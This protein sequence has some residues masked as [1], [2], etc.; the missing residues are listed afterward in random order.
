MYDSVS[1][2]YHVLYHS[3]N[4][5][6]RELYHSVDRLYHVQIPHACRLAGSN[7]V[8]LD[9]QTCSM[10]NTTFLLIPNAFE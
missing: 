1:I 5:L 6:Y 3:V 8:A 10:N 9:Q 7:K 4:T 2:L